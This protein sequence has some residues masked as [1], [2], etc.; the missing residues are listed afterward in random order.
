M[1]AGASRFDDR[2]KALGE[3]SREKERRLHLRAGHWHFVMDGAQPRW[4]NLQ[5]REIIFARANVRAHLAKWRHY[6][7]HRALLQGGIAGQLGSKVLSRQNS[8]EQADRCAGI[9]GIQRA[10]AA[11]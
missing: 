2:G 7:S 3:Q 6:A 4:A 11:F 5:W 1:V 10:P 8:R 9:A